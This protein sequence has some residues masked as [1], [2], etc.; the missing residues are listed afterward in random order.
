MKR[1]ILCILIT[2]ILLLAG[3]GQAA[4]PEAVS[5]R[6]AQIAQ[7]LRESKFSEV[8]AQGD[9]AFQAA[10]PEYQLQQAWCQVALGLG[11]YREIVD[12]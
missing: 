7:M 12:T 10:L 8:L 9:A 6:A 5:G 11:G 4:D 3:C 2:G 1:G